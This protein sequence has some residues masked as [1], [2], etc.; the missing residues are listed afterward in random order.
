[1]LLIARDALEDRRRIASGGLKGLA[2]SLARDLEPVLSRELYVP[3]AKALLSRAGGRCEQD[4]AYLTFD[5]FSPNEHCCPLCGRVHKGELHH[6]WWIYSYQLW[7]AERAAQ[8][9]VLH[10]LSGDARHRVLSKEILLRYAELYESYPNRDNALG[11]TRLFFSTYLESIWLL[12]I[13][14]ALD[15]LQEGGDRS[16]ASEVARR[17]VEP[18][19]DLIQQYDEGLSNRQVWNN[20]ALLAAWSILGDT[21]RVRQIVN[22]ASGLIAHLRHGLLSDGT[23][24][25]GDNYHLF[26]HRGLWYGVAMAEQ[27]AVSIE[28][29]LIARFEMGF[30]APFIAALPDLTFPSRKDSPYGVSLRQWRYAELCELGFARTGD[31]RL[32]AALDR[33]YDNQLEPG[34]TGRAES[35]AEAERNLPPV[36]LTRNDLGWRSLLFAVERLPTESARRE[37]RSQLM[38]G[39]GITIF[40]REQG[41]VYIAL[42]WG[43]SG[44]GHGHPDRLNVLFVDGDTR[45]LDDVGTGSYVDPSLHWYRSTLAHNAPLIDGHS[46]RRVDGHLQAHDERGDFGWTLAAVDGIAPGVHIERALIVTPDYFVDE[47]RWTADNE[48]RFELP[49]HFQG[50]SPSFSERGDASDVASALP[51]GGTDLE[52]GFRFVTAISRIEYEPGTVLEMHATRRTRNAR[53]FIWCSEGATIFKAMGPGVP[54]SALLPQSQETQ[55]ENVPFYLLS[56]RSRAGLVRAVWSWT[57]RVQGVEMEAD[58]IAVQVVDG[59]HQ[60]RRIDEGWAIETQ[61]QTILLKGIR[62][63]STTPGSTVTPRA[64]KPVEPSVLRRGQLSDLWLSDGDSVGSPTLAIYELGEKHYRRSEASWDAANRPTARVIIGAIGNELLIDVLVRNVRP[65][66]VVASAVNPYDN[67]AADIHGDGIQLY[68]RTATDSG[69]WMLVPESDSNAVRVRSIGG[70]GGLQLGA[71]RY[72]GTSSGYEVEARIPLPS[73]A[74]LRESPISMDILINETGEGRERRRGQLVMSGAQGEFIYLRGDRHDPARLIPL[75]ITD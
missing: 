54:S 20:A 14:V 21:Q 67:E 4:G 26:A 36:G 71:T 58:V 50:D 8:G 47:V 3:G 19:V 61:S 72:R 7:L 69:A 34:P 74:T 10:A 70:W 12:Q 35:T 59:F 33:L 27:A 41:R 30:A 56:A 18:S 28:P 42:D 17:V 46:Q 5:P 24:Y 45:W 13:C 52:D 57:D 15:L 43:Q 51:D 25:E 75:L 63:R 62:D 66:F 39:Q 37:Q 55:A 2:D 44:G 11:P 32:L 48:V 68:L 53:A 29:D 9:A 38:E 73:D 60:H 31:E 64:V 40:R 16:V 22:G 6:R 1:M 49:V 65:T 23:W